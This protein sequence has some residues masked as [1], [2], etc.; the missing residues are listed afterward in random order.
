MQ[1]ENEQSRNPILLCIIIYH[2]NVFLSPFYLG[3]FYSLKNKILV[4]SKLLDLN[5]I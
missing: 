4:Q 5:M 2:V 3:A 1:L